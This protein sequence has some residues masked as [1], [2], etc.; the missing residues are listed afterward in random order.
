[1]RGRGQRYS[2]T[3]RRA[4]PPTLPATPGW[5]SPGSA[6]PTPGAPLPGP[7]TPRLPVAPGW[8]MPGS[9]APTPGAPTPTPGAPTPTLPTAP[10]WFRPGSARGLPTAPGWLTPRSRACAPCGRLASIARTAT[11]NAAP[12]ASLLMRCAASR[13]TAAPRHVDEVV[14]L[15]RRAVVDVAALVVLDPA[16]RRCATQPAGSAGTTVPMAGEPAACACC[17]ATAACCCADRRLLMGRRGCCAVDSLLLLRLRRPPRTMRPPRTTR[18]PLRWS[19]RGGRPPCHA[20]DGQRRSGPADDRRR[21]AHERQT[22]S[23]ASGDTSASRSRGSATASTSAAFD[24]CACSS[25]SP[26]IRG[27]RATAS[28]AERTRPA[29]RRS[30]A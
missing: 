23:G 3:E 26:S 29:S 24:V 18:R 28:P 16:L 27:N 7:A 9:R 5:L 10:G 30:A 12:M 6:T 25:R 21:L 20:G 8:L 1:M 22:P 15:E 4:T 13:I 2:L 17:C 19:R 14:A 11:P